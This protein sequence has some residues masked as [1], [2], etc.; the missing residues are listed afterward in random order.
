MA[1]PSGSL[2]DVLAQALLEHHLITEDQLERCRA[3][4]LSATGGPD[5]ASVIITSGILDGDRIA[6][7]RGLV[8]TRG[9]KAPREFVSPL[10]GKV[11]KANFRLVRLLG[12]G[13]MGEVFL[14]EQLSVGR[15]VAIKI[16]P[17]A[18]IDSME[19][20]RRFEREAKAAGQLR[21]PNIVQVFDYD[22]DGEHLFIVM[23]Y[24]EG[25][26]LGHRLFREKKLPPAEVVRI[27]VEVARG[28]AAAHKQGFV[29]RDVKPENIFLSRDGLVKLGDFGLVRDLSADTLLSGG[30]RALGTPH[31]MSPEQCDAKEVGPA[32]DLYSL[33]ATLFH[34]ATGRFPFEG[35]RLTDVL[36]KH[37]TA[38]VPSPAALAPEIPRR[39]DAMIQKLLQKKPKARPG[40]AEEVVAGLENIQ[41]QAS[42][43][44]RPV[45]GRTPSASRPAT[46]PRPPSSPGV[47]PSS[48]PRPPSS[49][50]RSPSASRPP[51][52]PGASAASRPP[53]SAPAAAQVSPASAP[54]PPS[55]ASRPG[56][57]AGS[58]RPSTG[59]R[60]S[61]RRTEQGAG[62]S[63]AAL[64][65]RRIVALLL[66]GAVVVA[67]LTFLLLHRLF[68]SASGRS[69]EGG[70]VGVGAGE[71]G[72]GGDSGDGEGPPPESG[73]AGPPGSSVST[74]FERVEGARL[75]MVLLPAGRF[76]M[77][78]AE[79]A[80]P[81]D[82]NEQPA[83]DAQVE[84]FAIGR[85]EVTQGQ[86]EAVMGRGESRFPGKDSPVDAVSWREAV[87][88]CG[89]IA[90]LSGKPYRLPTEA[91]WE[92][93]CRAG[94]G[95]SGGAGPAGTPPP[96]AGSAERG[97]EPRDLAAFAW[98]SGNARGRPHPGGRR[99]ANAWGL[100]D[101]WGNVAEWCQ[102]RFLPY[103]MRPDDNRED[104]LD[105]TAQRVARGGSFQADPVFCRSASRQGLA[106][107]QA[108]H[109]VGFRVAC[110]V[111]KK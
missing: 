6:Q 82:R 49:S 83:F 101:M 38:P 88:F 37:L 80:K 41:A 5:L 65:R 32:A 34:L 29:H 13:G 2:D 58:G 28:L 59:Q 46:T 22:Q 14:A 63:V 54:R 25:E 3:L 110:D 90:T 76:R 87:A 8:E 27:G 102:S 111:G 45:P 97:G 75:E 20:L 107:D 67:A 23:E 17:L 24:V 70:G 11:L 61:P 95:P 86:F 64:E 81:C 50:G 104:P 100:F 36:S 94:G 30:W 47:R 44:D 55:S 26:T 9:L 96:G 109:P 1:S 84:A 16:L 103:P 78:S 4:Q 48:T 12:R 77:G 51:S 7:L 92:Y 18:R 69:A 72:V 52:S 33:G 60:P 40:S 43:A 74:Y 106:P 71:G 73:P 99:R 57:S 42:I 108:W 98:F 53:S 15:Q 19:V 93:A 56:R 89:R 79:T 105:L 31:Y 62:H 10:L 91:E 39:L 68:P 85:Y 21:H 66:V 35:T